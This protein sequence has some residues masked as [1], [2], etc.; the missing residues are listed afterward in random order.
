M[1]A[2]V[3]NALITATTTLNVSAVTA[4]QSFVWGCDR[5][6]AKLSFGLV[7]AGWLICVLAYRI[8]AVG[9]PPTSYLCFKS[10]LKSNKL[11][12][13]VSSTTLSGLLIATVIALTY[14]SA[15]RSRIH[16][17]T[18]PAY[19][20]PS[21]ASAWASHDA[22]N[23]TYLLQIVEHRG[24]RWWATMGLYFKILGTCEHLS[25]RLLFNLSILLGFADS[26]P[27]VK[28][29]RPAGI[30]L[31]LGIHRNAR[32]LS[33]IYA[34]GN[35][36]CIAG[37]K[38][39]RRQSKATYARILA[40]LVGE[41]KTKTEKCGWAWSWKDSPSRAPTYRQSVEFSYPCSQTHG[42]TVYI[43]S[44]YKR[45][46]VYQKDTPCHVLAN[47]QSVGIFYPYC[48]QAT[49]LNLLPTKLYSRLLPP[50]HTSA[51]EDGNLGNS[52]APPVKFDTQDVKQEQK[53]SSDAGKSMPQSY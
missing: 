23:T 14:L 13:I 3:F 26:R 37:K 20:K 27:A 47:C 53:K 5:K 11:F 8:I 44:Y 52:T 45:G 49:L 32:N 30:S 18:I 33:S 31:R 35:M 25:K 46:L 29:L 4:L 42:Q 6:N 1:H 41:K 40:V 48:H 28:W 12:V 17:I 36:E 39:S 21:C 38:H 15:P 22:I 2:K 16:P 51:G 34:A 24:W 50:S 10:V 9:N 7:V 43:R 19:I